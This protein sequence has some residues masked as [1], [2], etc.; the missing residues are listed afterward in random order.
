M[1]AGAA[2]RAADGER[3]FI[4]GAGRAGLGLARALGGSGVRVVGVHGRRASAGH[5]RITAGALPPAASTASV[6][7]LAVQDA[8]LEGALAEALAA[9]LADRAVVLSVSGS[10]EDAALDPA[11]ARGLA[12]GTFHPLLPLAN[13][14][15]APGL[16]RGGW[17]G[18]GGDAR[19]VA[20]A[21]A[22]AD[23]L[24][25]QTLA[26]PEGARARYHAAAVFASNFPTV[27]AATAGRL[28]TDAGVPEREAWGAVRGL[29]AAAAA[30]VGAASPSAALTGPVVRGDA[31]TVRRHLEALAGDAVALDAYRV[32]TRAAVELAREGG[33]DGAALDAVSEAVASAPGSGRRPSRPSGA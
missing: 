6:V 26:I 20:V 24:G 18:V 28:L 15:R 29:L 4:L 5:P 25:A 23:A 11:R 32:L 17:V 14:D 13:P 1:S 3:V 7:L 2:G 27:L 22:L 16:F 12:A 31:R 9:P 33:A 10:V 21:R 19:A 30:N 8:A